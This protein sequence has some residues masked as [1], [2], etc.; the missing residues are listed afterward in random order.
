MSKEKQ[1]EE[2]ALIICGFKDCT[3]C[4]SRMGLRKCGG[5]AY[6]E[7]FYNAGYRKQTETAREIFWEIDKLLTILLDDDETGR[8]YIAIDHLKYISL[9]KKYDGEDTNAPTKADGATDTKDGHKKTNFDRIKEMSVEELSE[10]LCE[11]YFEE[12]YKP[13]YAIDF[14]KFLESE[15]E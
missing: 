8:K 14:A 12:Q 3:D 6:A 13:E 4:I 5:K 7:R 10:F 15:V 11:I 9:K 1:I 2:M